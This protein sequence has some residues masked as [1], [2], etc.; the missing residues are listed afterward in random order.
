MQ[1]KIQR[2]RF[3]N[4][5]KQNTRTDVGKPKNCLKKEDLLKD[6]GE[7][8]KCTSK[9]AQIDFLH[10]LLDKFPDTD[11]TQ[12]CYTMLENLF[13]NSGND[14]ALV[15]LRRAKKKQN[16]RNNSNNKQRQNKNDIEEICNRPTNSSKK[17]NTSQRKSHPN[18]TEKRILMTERLN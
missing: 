4:R 17:K 7:I 15:L 16:K 11:S 8:R 1:R 9:N 14:K 2:M 18:S 10:K 3:K 13:S 12:N 6:I 5:K